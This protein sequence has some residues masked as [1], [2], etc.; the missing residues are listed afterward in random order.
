MADNPSPPDAVFRILIQADIRRVWREL[1]KTDEAQGAVFN[2][3][4]HSTGL[5]PG[6]RMQMRTGS[7]TASRN[8]MIRSA[9]WPTN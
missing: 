9:R 7:G 2:A 1:T 5:V 6:G 3:W 4:L 8:T